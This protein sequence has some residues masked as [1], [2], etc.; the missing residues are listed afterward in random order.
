MSDRRF[1]DKPSLAPWAVRG[2]NTD[3]PAM[4]ENRTLFP[5]TVV[6]VT[7]ADPDRILVSGV[8]NRKIGKVVEK[9]AFK[10]YGIFGISLEERAT[11]PSSCDVRDICYGNGMQLARRHRIGDPEVFYDRVTE[12]LHQHLQSYPD[13][14]V[15]LHVLGDFPSVDYV[16]FWK[17]ILD[18]MP[19]VAVYGYTHRTARS[20]GGDDIGDAIEAVKD[21][22][23]DRFRIRW[24]TPASRPDGTVVISNVPHGARSGGNEIVCPAQRDTSECCATCA[25]CWERAASTECIAFI[26]HGPKSDAAAAA[27]VNS[28]RE[29]TPKRVLGDTRSLTPAYHAGE[30]RP[31]RPMPVSA[32]SPSV[33]S[34]SKP[35]FISVDPCLL[36]METKYQRDLSAKSMK[37]IRKIVGGFD[38]RKY[39]PPIC[40]EEDGRYYVVDGQHTAISAASHPDIDKIPVMVVDA[41]TIE[42]RAAS[43]VAHNRD[44]VA[45]SPYQVFHGEVAAGDPDARAINAAVEAGGGAIPRYPPQRGRYK[46]GQVSA[47][48]EVRQIFRVDGAEKLTAIVKMAVEANC[49]PIAATVIRG[50]RI[51]LSEPEFSGVSRE[52]I[53]TA[54]MSRPDLDDASRRLASETRQGRGRAAAIILYRAASA[55]SRRGAA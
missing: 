32:L 3:H 19:G 40:V 1:T 8:N 15:R 30:I 31:V 27:T 46:A 52:D 33:V 28:D 48:A 2:L 55:L 47:V 49:K 14:L 9:G 25:L 21:A 20:W 18:D 36:M 13:V 50:L 41:G 34:G 42:A 45:M 38:W 53:V 24:S 17:E 39:K 23:P 10:G 43:F 35:E 54:L 5:S 44:R 51:L 11:C 4:L 12:E 7:E 6:T 37:L 26:K 22:H 29:E 16:A